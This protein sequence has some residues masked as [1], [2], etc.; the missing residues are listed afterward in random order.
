MQGGWGRGALEE[1]G[2]RKSKIDFGKAMEQI[3]DNKEREMVQ[4]DALW[5][6]RLTYQRRGRELLPSYCQSA[7]TKAVQ[8]HRKQPGKEGKKEGREGGIKKKS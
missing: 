4:T 5:E 8:T 7:E 2:E 1:L 3:R 6:H